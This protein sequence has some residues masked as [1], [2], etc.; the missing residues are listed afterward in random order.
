MK[1]FPWKPRL[2]RDGRVA[3][4]GRRRRYILV[5]EG[6]K[7]GRM[8]NTYINGGEIYVAG[9]NHERGERLAI[10]PYMD[11]YMRLEW[12]SKAWC[13]ALTYREPA[14]S[15]TA[16][17]KHPTQVCLFCTCITAWPGGHKENHFLCGH[18]YFNHSQKCH[19]SLSPLPC[20]NT[21]V[22]KSP[23]GMP[24]FLSALQGFFK[25]ITWQGIFQNKGLHSWREIGGD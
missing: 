12:G 6:E 2:G 20:F 24:I 25:G 15:M 11:T 1:R 17:R 22:S 3:L 8:K 21:Q 14:E 10:I 5:N 18:I 16:E 4:R 7:I 13:N 19:K 9:W 23:S